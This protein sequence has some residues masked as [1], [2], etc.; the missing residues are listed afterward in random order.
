MPCT[1]Q[2]SDASSLAELRFCLDAVCI[3]D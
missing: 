3:T 2:H 1:I